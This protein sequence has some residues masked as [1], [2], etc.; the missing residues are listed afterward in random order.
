MT[1][2]GLQKWYTSQFDKLGWMVL[3]KAKGCG[4]RVTT[5]KKTVKHLKSSIEHLMTEYK[6]PDRIHDLKV[7]H[8]NVVHLND[9]IA[10][11][12]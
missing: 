9:F 12:L 7:L 8:M 10:K 11:H 1:M 3:A 4:H 5:Y 2:D 6:D